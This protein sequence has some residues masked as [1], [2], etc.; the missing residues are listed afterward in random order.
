MEGLD[1]GLPRIHLDQSRYA[2][3]LLAV[4]RDVLVSV[5]LKSVACVVLCMRRQLQNS[6]AWLYAGS[7][8][9]GCMA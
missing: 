7:W 9:H 5:A 1:I 6:R 3:I 2:K 8:P 4:C